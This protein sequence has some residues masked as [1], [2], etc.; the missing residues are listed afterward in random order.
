[1]V[2]IQK[3]NSHLYNRATGTKRTKWCSACMTSYLIVSFARQISIPASLV[4]GYPSSARWGI[5]PLLFILHHPLL[6]DHVLWHPPLSST[7]VAGCS[8]SA[9]Y[10]KTV[11][12][13]VGLW[14]S[15][16]AN[17]FGG[18][19]WWWSWWRGWWWCGGT[20]EGYIIC[21]RAG[22]FTWDFTWRLLLRG[23]CFL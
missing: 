21:V 9:S 20:V 19:Q 4:G 2:S 5:L 12:I 13:L 6:P 15:C 22:S 10:L 14:C 8:S 18:L 16:H 11:C 23:E 1:M 17:K 3:D 7:K